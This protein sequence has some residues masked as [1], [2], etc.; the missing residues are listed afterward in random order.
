ME[1]LFDLA[2]NQAQL[3]PG[4]TMLAAKIGGVWQTKSCKSVV[5]EAA[6]FADA[7]LTL[8]IKNQILEAEQQEKIALVSGNRPEWLV[9]D[10]AVQQTGAILVPLYP[11]ISMIEFA[12]I[13]N[14]SEVRILILSDKAMYDRFQPAFKDIP[15]LKFIFSFDEVEGAK[16]WK[17]LK[18][19]S[20]TEHER[21]ELR[22]R[23]TGKTLATIIYTSGTTG[24]PKGVM[25]SHE[26]IVSNVLDCAPI[27]HFGN[28]EDDALSFLPLNHIFEKTISYIYINAGINIYYAESM[29]TIGDNL[30][31]IQPVVFSCVPR[32]MEKVYE[33][34][35]GKGRELTGV[36][37]A[38]FFWALKLGKQ[39]DTQVKGTA[40]YRFQLNLANKIIFKK[41]REALGGNVKAIVSG[42]APLPDYLNRIF[43][44]ARIP[45]MEGYGLTETSPVVSVTRLEEKER[46]IG[47]VGELIQNVEIKIAEDGE[48]LC[49][50]KNV[51]VGY[52]KN[53]E[54][55]AKAIDSEGWF[56]TGDIGSLV[57]G[58]YIKITDRKKEMF[59]TSG[60]KY[61]AP[62]PIENKFKESRFIGQIMIIGPQ[63]KFVSAL[64]VPDFNNVYNYL[65]FQCPNISDKPKDLI[66]DPAVSTLFKGIMDK[67][68]PFFNHIEQIKKY[69]LLP[70]EWTIENGI[71]TP[72]L[73]LK[74]KVVTERFQKEIDAM[75]ER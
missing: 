18:G 21:L 67:Y 50:G 7:L 4:S 10:L 27:F 43:C 9:A 55:T 1:R 56:H 38:L 64:I 48:I 13:L 42:S 17:S 60:G 47:T 23:I 58:K 8:E 16:Q 3:R 31:E 30:R 71:L 5:H 66:A 63:R 68:N 20:R 49:R 26:N 24:V 53:P 75:Y 74:R 19:D 12:Y 57:A 32:V 34:I 33:K 62:Q 2:E 25:L 37:K 59:K 36:K 28:V 51:M 6:A 11:T 15:T 40:W 61:V 52:Y 46:I 72:K 22:Q 35:V 45:I 73:S 29:D 14:Q 39:Y 70:D 44:A 69:T 41:W 65:K 54:E